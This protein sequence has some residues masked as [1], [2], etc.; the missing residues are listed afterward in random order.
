MCFKKHKLKDKSDSSSTTSSQAVSEKHNYRSGEIWLNVFSIIFTVIIFISCGWMFCETVKFDPSNGEYTE[1]WLKHRNDI[2]HYWYGVDSV[3]MAKPLTKGDMLRILKSQEL[4]L[5]RQDVLVDDVRQ[6]TN[7]LINKM[8][9]WLGFWIGIVALVGVF[10]P[11]ALQF[12]LY[13]ES[14]EK[15]KELSDK[16][17]NALDSFRTDLECQE[18][19]ILGRVREVTFT[20]L[21]RNFQNVFECPVAQVQE[22]RNHILQEILSRI[23]TRVEENIRLYCCHI[24][25]NEKST[26]DLKMNKGTGETRASG[27]TE[28]MSEYELTVMLIQVTNVINSIKKLAQHRNRSL[29]RILIQITN[30]I[31]Y[32]NTPGVSQSEIICNLQ[33]FGISLR[34][35]SIPA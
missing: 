16:I 27:C 6:E 28:E 34:L 32:L 29:D 4:V 13:R 12:K 2:Q 8:N 18:R 10:V 5:D 35:L 26:E 22:S 7:N 31:S 20:T 17:T 15:E 3:G 33:D 30:L 21:V 14:K 11:V 23:K 25:T 19:E 9:G 1:A 24:N